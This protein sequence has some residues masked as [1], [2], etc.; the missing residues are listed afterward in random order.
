M[1]RWYWTRVE[2]ACIARELG[3]STSG[4][5]DDLA[6]RVEAALAGRPLPEKTTGKRCRLDGDLTRETVIPE[7]VVLSRH[8]REWFEIELGPRFRFDRHLREFLRKG[9]GRTLGEAADHYR[10]TRD[11]GPSAIESQFELN[12]FTRLWW[13]ANP[14]GMREDLKRAWSEYRDTP[15]DQ[16]KTPE[17]PS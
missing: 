15:A 13:K 1:K 9:G 10:E 11:A 4:S 17:I 7:G 14:N 6:A 8:L 12:R 16:R 5:K 2:L 3:I